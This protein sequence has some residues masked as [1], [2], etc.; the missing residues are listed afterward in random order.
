MEVVTAGMPSKDGCPVLTRLNAFVVSQGTKVQLE[1]VW[2]DRNG[3][4]KDLSDYLPPPTSD[5]DSDSDSDNVV[6]GFGKISVRIREFLGTGPSSSSDP[7][8]EIQGEAVDAVAGVIRVTIDKTLTCR[9]GIYEVNWGVKDADGDLVLSA[10]SLMSIERSLFADRNTERRGDG[11]PTLQEIR[12]L[13]MDSAP[14]ENLLL[15]D[16]EFGDEQICLAM[17]RPVQKWNESPPPIKTFTTRTF[18]FRGAWVDG[19]MAELYKMAAA[20][21]R[22]NQLASSAAGVQTDIK[23]KEREYMAAAKELEEKYDAWLINKKVECNMKLF[24]GLS[25]S[26]YSTR[27]GW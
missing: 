24:Q 14:S 9:P 15:A 19:I 5:S 8:W 10:R 7:L 23:N 3:S 17:T 21:Y 26:T 16:V 13:M 22:R 27:T 1:Y 2:R 4:P 25:L 12:M 18:P 11:P 20:H 6:D